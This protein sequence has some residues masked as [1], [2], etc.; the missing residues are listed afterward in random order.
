[1]REAVLDL[2][3][4]AIN[5]PRESNYG[6]PYANHKRIADIWSAMTGYEFTPSMVSAMMIGIKLAR[7]KE[8]IGVLD[9][10]VDIAGYSAITWE[11]INEERK[12]GVKK[13]YHSQRFSNND[14]EELS[15]E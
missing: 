3:K 14:T 5:G 7:A 12:A 13:Q 11:I 15:E 9:N 8:D 6:S 4:D 10:W 1:M 2:A